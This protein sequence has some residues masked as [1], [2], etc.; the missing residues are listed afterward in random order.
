MEA[1][2]RHIN[3]GFTNWDTHSKQVS[4]TIEISQIA[5]VSDTVGDIYLQESDHTDTG[6]DNDLEFIWSFNGSSSTPAEADGYQAPVQEADATR[7]PTSVAL[8]H[9]RP[10]KDENL[11]NR[12]LSGQPS[13]PSVENNAAVWIRTQVSFFK[14]LV[15]ESLLSRVDSIIQ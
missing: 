11:L 6:R 9:G 10:S 12:I 14:R 1:V 15:M 8:R 13:S 7:G 4:E 5:A 2:F 3:G